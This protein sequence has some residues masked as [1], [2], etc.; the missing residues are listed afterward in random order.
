MLSSRLVIVS[1]LIGGAMSIA[2]GT[3]TYLRGIQETPL[4]PV[5]ALAQILPGDLVPGFLFTIGLASLCLALRMEPSALPSSPAGQRP[6]RAVKPRQALVT[7][8]DGDLIARLKESFDPDIAY[9]T[10]GRIQTP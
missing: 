10:S 4:W 5:N 9:P 3:V 6:G 8:S 1:T 7:S 2:F